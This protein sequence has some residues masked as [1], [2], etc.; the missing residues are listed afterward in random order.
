MLTNRL[1][2]FWL[3]V[4]TTLVVRC[5]KG[6]NEPAPE[7]RIRQLEQQVEQEKLTTQEA[8][9]SY[10]PKLPGRID[11]LA[12]PA[13]DILRQLPWRSWSRSGSRRDASCICG[14][15]TS[16]TSSYLVGSPKECETPASRSAS[17]LRTCSLVRPEGM[18]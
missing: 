2:T 7:N 13:A 15:G 3:A 11:D 14:T 5:S 12:A 10:V 9:D 6:T 17:A 18:D 16:W 8:A 1:N 4:V